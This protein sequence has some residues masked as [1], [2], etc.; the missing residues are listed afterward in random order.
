MEKRHFGASQASDWPQNCCFS[1]LTMLPTC[2]NH[3]RTIS[4]KIIVDPK[5]AFHACHFS[6]FG[7]RPSSLDSF[8]GYRTSFGQVSKTCSSGCLSGFSTA[9]E[10][11]KHSPFHLE[12]LKRVL[13]HQKKSNTSKASKLW[14][15]VFHKILLLWP[16]MF[17]NELRVAV[18][19]S[20]GCKQSLS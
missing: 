9:W 2:L 18:P 5:F 14:H 11:A 3:F 7:P 10:G 13:Y 16:V 19:E 1:N 12:K 20:Y 8:G 4:E 15:L 6:V 17:H